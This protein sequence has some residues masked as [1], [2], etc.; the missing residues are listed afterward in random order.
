[1]YTYIHTCIY[2]YIYIYRN[3]YC[4]KKKKNW[5]RERSNVL[6]EHTH[7]YI[8]IPKT[9]MLHH[10]STGHKW[11]LPMQSYQFF[12]QYIYI[13]IYIYIYFCVHFL[14]GTIN[15]ATNHLDSSLVV[16]T[17]NQEVCS[18]CGLRLEPCGCSYDSHW[19]LTWSLTSGPVELVE[20]GTNWPD[21]HVKLKNK[22]SD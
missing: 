1:M 10:R 2:I 15:T 12:R 6:S 7:L 22:H 19:R 8:F 20:V 14:Y 16:R 18:F 13:Y 17:W 9:S 4:K 3:W 21:T 11:I 5:K